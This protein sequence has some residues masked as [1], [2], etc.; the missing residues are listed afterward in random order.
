MT[1]DELERHIE[2][3][4]IEEVGIV[5]RLAD[6]VSGNVG[7]DPNCIRVIAAGAARVVVYEV[8]KE[9]AAR[10]QQGRR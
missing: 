10:A 2:A 8:K 1:D 7:V 6:D 3:L 4:L 9:L 5:Y